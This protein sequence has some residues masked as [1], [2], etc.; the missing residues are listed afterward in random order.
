MW[1]KNSAA[2]YPKWVFNNRI[3]SWLNGCA[4][5]LVNVGLLVGLT[6]VMT[7]ASSLEKNTRKSEKGFFLQK[8]DAEK[9]QQGTPTPYLT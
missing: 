7:L 8:F 4:V 9:F 6:S 2:I 1:F 5:I 3:N